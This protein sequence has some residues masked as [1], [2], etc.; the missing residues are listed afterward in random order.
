MNGYLIKYN[1][2]EHITNADSYEEAED[3]FAEKYPYATIEEYT[4][5]QM[6]IDELKQRTNAIFF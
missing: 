1:N 4:I 6:E 2:T 3:K 5:D